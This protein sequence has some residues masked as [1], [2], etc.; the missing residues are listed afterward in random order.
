MDSSELKLKIIREIDSLGKR[1]LQMVYGYLQNLNRSES[2]LAEWEKLTAT[3]KNG[4][5]EAITELK[6]VRGVVHE[7]VISKY[8]KKLSDA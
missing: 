3:E 5:T 7:N 1:K 8:R 4:I 6:E 2:D